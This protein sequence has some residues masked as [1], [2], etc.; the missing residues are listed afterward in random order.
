MFS[1]VLIL[2]WAVL[3]KSYRLTWTHKAFSPANLDM[4]I[5]QCMKREAT[6]STCIPLSPQSW[7]VNRWV[8]NSFL[9]WKAAR[10]ITLSVVRDRQITPSFHTSQERVSSKS[11][12]AGKYKTELLLANAEGKPETEFWFVHANQ[13]AAAQP[14]PLNQIRPESNN[15]SL[16]RILEVTFPLCILL[17]LEKILQRLKVLNSSGVPGSQMKP[18]IE[19]WEMHHSIQYC[20]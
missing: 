1:V 12:P 9:W 15:H 3:L 13:K 16:D 5:F 17:L 2:L 11:S 14:G 19:N 7:P 4:L 20:N 6:G 10:S 8:Q 18:H